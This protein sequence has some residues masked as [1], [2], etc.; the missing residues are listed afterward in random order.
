MNVKTV[1]SFSFLFLLVISVIPNPAQTATIAY[2]SAQPL[3]TKISSIRSQDSIDDL[4][5]NGTHIWSTEPPWIKNGNSFVPYILNQT[6]NNIQVITQTGSYLFDKTSCSLS[7]YGSN[8]TSG[9]PQIGSDSFTVK[10]ELNGTTTWNNVSVINNASCQTSINQTGNNLEIIGTKSSLN[11]GVFKIH[12]LKQDGSKLKTTIEA[13]NNNPSWTNYHLGISEKLNVART[14]TL[15]NQTYDLSNYNNT[16]LSRAW[17]SN[18]QS[19]LVQLG[20]KVNFDFTLAWNYVSQITIQYKNN[21]ASLV[22]DYTNNT[23]ILQPGHT[24]SIDP[25]YGYSTGT[26]NFVNTNLSTG[27]TCSTAANNG[28][29]AVDIQIPDSTVSNRCYRGAEEY[30]I[31]SIP[32]NAKISSVSL[33][34][35]VTIPTGSG[36]NGNVMR[37]GHPFSYYGTV[38][39]EWD[40]IGNSTI[41]L[42]NNAWTAS[43]GNNKILTLSS[44]ANTDIMALR[45]LGTNISLGFKFTDENRTSG[46]TYSSEIDDGSSKRTLLKIVYSIPPSAPTLNSITQISSSSLN[47]TWSSSSGATWYFENRT[48]PAGGILVNVVNTT[49]LFHV[50][51]G[52][53]PGTQYQYGIQ[54]GSSSGFSVVSNKL[55]KYTV[56]VAP[57]SL[58]T[59]GSSDTIIR[60]GWTNPSGNYSSFKVEK[61]AFDCTGFSTVTSD[62]GNTTNRYDVSGLSGNTKYCFRVS[63]NYAKGSADAGTSSPSST[64]TGYTLPSPPTGLTVTQNI[65]KQA[66]LSWTDG[67]GNG[68]VSGYFIEYSLNSGTTWNTLIANTGNTSTTFNS[69][70]ILGIHS[71]RVSTIKQLGTSLPS[72]VATR[73][74]WQTEKVT[75]K[76]A[77]VVT[78]LY[79]SILQSNSTSSNN[80][81]TL[82]SGVTNINGTYNNQNFSAKNAIVNFIVKKQYNYNTTAFSSLN[83]TVND[84]YVDCPSSGVGNDIELFTNETDGHRISSFPAPTCYNNNTVKW[85]PYFKANGQSSSTYSTVVW[86]KIINGTFLNNATLKANATK[87][88]TVLSNPYIVSN[89]IPVGSGLSDIG[90]Y[91]SMNLTLSPGF[92]PVNFTVGSISVTG[93]NHVT[94]PITFSSSAVNSSATAVTVKF[95][96]TYNMG[97]D[98]TF[99]DEGKTKTLTG[100]PTTSPSLGISQSVITFKNPQND[101][102]SIKAY[103]LVSKNNAT[104]QMT[105]TGNQ[106][107]FVQQI[108]NFQNGT[109]GTKGM[110]GTIDIVTLIVL[111]I[112]MIGLNR[113]NET[114]GAVI[115]IMVI[116]G[117]A[118]FGIVQWPTIMT[119]AIALVVLVIV[120]STKKLPWS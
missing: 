22:I 13:T 91:L 37:M 119:A 66:K 114:V 62:T 65:S 68:T 29:T 88:T 100:L 17:I 55:S 16:I 43:A 94:A 39:A 108:K 109:F 45:Q 84:F 53:T 78:A 67:G 15:G 103:D 97:Y 7:F 3:V 74:I 76:L 52:L 8:N 4:Y 112:A 111:I 19:Q 99:N 20:N 28:N 83:M 72:N 118:Y 2:G 49:S 51:T 69:N 98:L 25:T 30:N 73:T 79:G 32:T 120:S 92:I 60:V 36:R 31:G 105:Q 10:A 12:Y 80:I 71:Y 95:P 61:G 23:P 58:T 77:D 14:I 64:A 85:H 56:N 90:L 75:A 34:S 18:H 9:T 57:T 54:A 87:I 6:A 110:I 102:V 117:I 96:S 59:T 24:I 107:P 48:S 47:V 89:T 82:F 38:Q 50:D 81:F 40:A 26:P 116:G 101:T 113:V 42:Y 46:T 93:S 5:S 115:M 86:V 35:S 21:Q 41:Y 27:S 63:T 33:N 44:Q 11:N 106:I 70:G 1:L 104:Y